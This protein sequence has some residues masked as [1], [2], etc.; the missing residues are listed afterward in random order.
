LGYFIR[1]VFGY[2]CCLSPL[3]LILIA[4]S[5]VSFYLAQYRDGSILIAI[6]TL[7]A[8]IGFY[9]EWKSEN[10]LDSLKGLVVDKCNVIR[11]GKI[12]EI[13]AYDLVPGDIVKLSEGDG[14]PADIRLIESNEYSANEFILTGESLPANKDSLFTTDKILPLN[15]IKNAFTWEQRLP[16]VMLQELFM[17]PEYKRRLVKSVP[18]LKKLRPPMLRCKLKLLMLPKI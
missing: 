3:V 5:A 18:R 1:C 16:A 7:N 14:I 4:A 9:E 2:L 13:P 17:Q 11:N 6:V 12:I 15:E 8:I 10:I